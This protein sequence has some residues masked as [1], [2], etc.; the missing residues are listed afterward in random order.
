M[1]NNMEQLTLD[2]DLPRPLDY[3]PSISALTTLQKDRASDLFETALIGLLAKKLISLRYGTVYESYF[4]KQFRP[5]GLECQIIPGEK[6]SGVTVNGVLEQKIL[7]I[8][9]RWFGVGDVVAV[10]EQIEDRGYPLSIFQLVKDVYPSDQSNPGRWLIKKVE[11][12][13]VTRRLGKRAGVLKK[14]LELDPAHLDKLRDEEALLR[15]VRDQLSQFQPDLVQVMK[16]QIKD[17]IEARI[18]VSGPM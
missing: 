18:W 10:M 12:D 9:Q 3:P 4:N 15:S 5:K 8:V 6:V 11:Q 17:G 13:A 1:V 16:T 7:N 14:H 2:L